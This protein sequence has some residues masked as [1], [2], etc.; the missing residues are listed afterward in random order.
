VAEDSNYYN[1][2]VKVAVLVEKSFQ[3]RRRITEDQK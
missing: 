1:E 3:L 2:K